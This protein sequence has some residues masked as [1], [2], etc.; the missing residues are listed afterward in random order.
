MATGTLDAH[1]HIFVKR[2]RT[3][4]GITAF[5]TGIAVGDGKPGEGRIRDV[6][7]RWSIRRRVGTAMACR[8]L[9]RH[10]LLRVVPA[11]RF[12]ARHT[13]ATQAIG[14]GRDVGTGL[15]GGTAAVVTTCAIG[16]RR[17]TAVVHIAGRQPRRSLVAFVARIC[18]CQMRRGFACRNAAVVTAR[19]SPGSYTRMAEFSP[20]K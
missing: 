6:V 9:A 17:K 13:V 1:R 15:A 11:G 10:D 5:V 16:C 18:C 7:R 14:R 19:A 8:T 3:P 12:P 20:G 2:A 4:A